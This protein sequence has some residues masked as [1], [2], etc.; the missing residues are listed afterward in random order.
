MYP[1]TKYLTG[2][3]QEKL[4]KEF[5][6]VIDKRDS[7]LIKKALYTF[8]H[9]N[10]GFIYH[11]NIHGF[12]ETYSELGFRDFIIHF[13]LLHSG[14]YPWLLNRNSD[15]YALIKDM[16][17]YATAHASNIYAELDN[18][19]RN[20]EIALAQRL[21]QKHGVTI[22]GEEEVVGVQESL[23]DFISEEDGQMAIGF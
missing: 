8:L 14:H 9:C 10:T 5:K 6:R 13:D 17:N 1:D 2:K 12:R 18:R 7:S 11:Y 15:Y 20:S 21:L 23:Y 4:F 16:A 19:Q 3:D 22:P